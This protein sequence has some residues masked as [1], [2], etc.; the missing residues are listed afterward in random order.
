[1]EEKKKEALRKEIG[2]RF[3]EFR[4]AMKMKRKELANE[5]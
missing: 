2:L 3:K 4:K 1:M 5:Y